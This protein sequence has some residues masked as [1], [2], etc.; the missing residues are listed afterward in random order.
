MAA[1]PEI[2]FSYDQ[3][4][5]VVKRFATS[6]PEFLLRHKSTAHL[7]FDLQRLRLIESLDVRFTVAIVGQM[8]VGKS[9]LLN[10]L[11][12]ANLAPTGVTET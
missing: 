2:A 12:G 7:A 10:A 11:I 4:E 8:R 5:D 3:F 6:M 9:T 1:V